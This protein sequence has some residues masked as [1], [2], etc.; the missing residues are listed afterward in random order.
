MAFAEAGLFFV[1]HILITIEKSR[2]WQMAEK[3]KDPHPFKGEG[4]RINNNAEFD[5]LV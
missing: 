2:T 4:P 3:K 5:F 1:V